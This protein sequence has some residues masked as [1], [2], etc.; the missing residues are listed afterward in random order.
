MVKV[1]S[2]SFNLE[3]PRPIM[4]IK[5][6]TQQKSRFLNSRQIYSTIRINK[7]MTKKIFETKI[8]LIKKFIDYQIQLTDL[9][10][11]QRIAKEQL[12]EVYHTNT[13]TDSTLLNQINLSYSIIILIEHGFYGSARVLLRQF[14]EFLI[15]GKFSEFD[16]GNIIQKWELKTENNR[17]FDLSL[18][19]DVLNILSKKK[20]ISQI[21][22]TWK[23]LSDFSHPTRYAQQVPPFSSQEDHLEWM[24]MS[25]PNIHYT[26]DLF[27]VV[28]CMNY[29][30]LTSN[31]GRKSRGWYFG[32][33]KDSL[34]LWKREKKSKENSKV[35]VK[36]YFEIN[37]KH[38]NVNKE[39]KKTIFQYR[40]N[41]SNR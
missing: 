32:Y 10:F 7:K 16:K 39:L 3:D 6:S 4:K 24:K 5:K 36:K 18:S 11:R 21:R 40:Q 14:F 12:R 17:E 13:V 28:L 22:K 19:R 35:L 20:D 25:Y 27:F 30:L 37:Q 9:Y 2:L 26:L 8:N 1:T 38:G 15:I 31:W 41:W 33:P 23:I 34:G 29:H